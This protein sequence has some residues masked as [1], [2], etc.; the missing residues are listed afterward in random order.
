MSYTGLIGEIPIGFDGFSSSKN[1]STLLP[2]QILQALN[3]TYESGTI[4]KEGGSVTFN[5]D[6]TAVDGAVTILGGWDW[7][8]TIATQRMIVVTSNG[9]IFKDDMSGQFNTT[10]ATGLTVSSSVPYFVEGGK[11]AA[12]NNRKLF[13][14]TGQNAVQ[15]LSADGATTAA[16][17]TPPA[18]WATG[19]PT[20][21]CNHEG[22]LWGFGNTNDPHRLYFST[23]TD[24]ENF[25]GGTAGS[26]AIY[27]GD[28]ETI[29]AAIPYGAGI[30]VL[31]KPRGI[32]FVDTSNVTVA[33]WRINKITD[34]IGAVG[35]RA[36]CRIDADILIMDPSG[37]FHLVSATDQF[38]DFLSST[39]PF[40]HEALAEFVRTN[41]KQSGLSDA[42]AIYYEAKREAHFAVPQIGS[43]IN[44]L[45]L[46]IDFSR[47]ERPRARYSDKDDNESLWLMTVSGVPRPM[48]GDNIGFVWRLDQE[49]RVST[50]NSTGY[51]MI[52]QTVHDDFAR[53]D[54]ALGTRRKNGHFLEIVVEPK[55]NWNLSVDIYWD[56]ELHETVQFNMGSSGA[57]LGSFILGTSVLAGTQVLNKKRRITGGGRRF[58]MVGRNSGAFEDI[59][60]AKAYLHFTAGDERL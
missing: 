28:S 46:V 59:S 32:Y 27:P 60:I 38:G 44:D 47:Q 51:S 2:T 22:R 15:V 45:R 33:N 37:E 43:S 10:L 41:V 4:R 26:L 6:D 18:D 50:I 20:G 39:V 55:G 14:F 34:G 17:T 5:E 56:A 29:V 13:I 57:T 16:L 49:D 11:E 3:I 7:N 42:Q 30:V 19:N 8:P 25:T 53:L 54:P 40:I 36:W 9:K 1:L 23:T 31:K 24:H 35:V 12:A 48:A 58:S 21:G 52:F